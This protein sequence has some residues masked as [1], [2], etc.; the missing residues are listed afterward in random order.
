VIIGISRYKNLPPKAQLRFANRDPEELATFLR[1]PNGGGFP[2]SNIKILMDA[3][4]SLASVRTALGTWL[5]RST[6]PSDV[7]YIFFAGHG[8][9]E[10]EQEG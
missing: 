2:S 8:V 7:V 9:V 5:I 1:S 6:E 10:N 4:A 3:E